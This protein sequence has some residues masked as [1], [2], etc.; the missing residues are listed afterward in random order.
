MDAS[1]P[2]ALLVCALAPS[3]PSVPA[4]SPG[5]VTPEAF[6]AQVRGLIDARAARQ[7]G[8]KSG[9]DDPRLRI[10]LSMLGAH[11]A[12]PQVPLPEVVRN[13]TSLE[14]LWGGSSALFVIELMD[15]VSKL[16]PS[17]KAT[18]AGDCEAL[19]GALTRTAG[20]D[21]VQG[22]GLA[23]WPMPAESA[24]AIKAASSA[25]APDCVQRCVTLQVPN[26]ACVAGIRTQA[27][28]NFC[29]KAPRTP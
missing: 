9:D 24:A 7:G 22:L 12:Q 19:C 8:P 4:P 25:T 15:K 27:E 10:L 18:S 23:G 16:R 28:L 6:Q 1:L 17:G 29:W 13:A 11:A 21:T 20:D 2:F 5:T 3:A 14:A 26:A